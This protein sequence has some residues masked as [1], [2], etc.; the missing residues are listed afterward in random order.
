MFAKNI[1]KRGSEDL[2]LNNKAE[3]KVSQFFEHLKLH[4]SLC[5]EPFKAI[6][7]ST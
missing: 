3:A 4:H 6:E 2:F 5:A 7:L 1:G